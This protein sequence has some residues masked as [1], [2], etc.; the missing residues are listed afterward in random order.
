MWE[1]VHQLQPLHF[2]RFFC[3]KAVEIDGLLMVEMR[4]FNNDGSTMIIRGGNVWKRVRFTKDQTAIW[5]AL[6][7]EVP[8]YTSWWFQPS[9]K[10]WSSNWIISLRGEHKK[11][12][13][14][15]RSIEQ[16]FG[17]EES[18]ISGNLLTPL[19]WANSKNLACFCEGKNIPPGLFETE[20]NPLPRRA[21]HDS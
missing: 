4:F 9:W 18:F 17:F 11:M 7:N 1:K 21:L 5:N 20:A 19:P 10:V 6:W 2:H 16:Q 3:E 14:T 8:K 15:P 12:F 13:K